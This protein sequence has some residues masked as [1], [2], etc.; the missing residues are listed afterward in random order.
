KEGDAV[1]INCNSSSTFDALF[2]YKQDAGEGLVLLITLYKGGDMTRNGK[3]T[4]YKQSQTLKLTISSLTLSDSDIYFC[5]HC[6]ANTGGAGY[7]KLTFGQ[8]TILT[9]HPNIKNPDPAVYQ[10]KAPKSSNNISVCLYTDFQVNATEGTEPVVLGSNKTVS[11]KISV[12]DMEAVGSKSNGLVA[13]SNSIDF[14][15]QNSKKNVCVF[16]G[17]SCDAKLVEKSF[18]TDMNLNLQN[19]TVIGFRILL[20]KM[21]GFN[22]LMTLRLWSS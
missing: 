2:W 18:E 3:L 15:C 10:L 8:G 14:E 5:L 4:F 20:L 11:S 7:G 19:L 22:L 12:L 17:I 6:S 16:S 21:V 1:S 13:W 9:V